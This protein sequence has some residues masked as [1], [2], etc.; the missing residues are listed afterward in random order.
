MKLHPQDWSDHSRELSQLLARSGLGDRQAFAALYEKT[1]AHLFGVVLRIQRDRT[2]AEELLQEIYVSVWKAAAGFD[3]AQS[4]PLT[5]LTCIAL[6][7]AIDSPRRA[8]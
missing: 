8:Q 4:Q 1:S 5:W 3:A 6:N 7:R 2:L